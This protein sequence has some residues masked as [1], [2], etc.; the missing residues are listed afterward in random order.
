[1][2]WA[3]DWLVCCERHASRAIICHFQELDRPERGSVSRISKASDARAS[4]IQKNMKITFKPNNILGI[5]VHTQQLFLFKS[6]ILSSNLDVPQLE[7][8]FHEGTD[9][10]LLSTVIISETRIASD[11]QQVVKNI[12]QMNRQI[13]HNVFNH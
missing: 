5:M 12:C 13:N 7:Y 2:V 1:M 11:I 8:K 6:F 4:Q 10:S 9:L 3:L